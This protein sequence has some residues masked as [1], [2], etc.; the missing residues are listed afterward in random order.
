MC[1][2]VIDVVSVMEAYF[3]ML[4]ICIVHCAEGYCLQ[5]TVSFCTVHNTDAQH[6]KICRHNIDN[7]NNDMHIGTRYVLLAEHWM[8]LPD[9]GF[10]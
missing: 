5:S 4:C 1:Y 6:V 10:T 7:I 9:D 3:D 8:W 2:V